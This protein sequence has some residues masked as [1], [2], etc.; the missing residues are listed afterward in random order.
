MPAESCFDCV[1]DQPGMPLYEQNV[2]S[3]DQNLTQSR[4]L[5]QTLDLPWRV[6]VKTQLK[7]LFNLRARRFR[8][9]FPVLSHSTEDHDTETDC[10]FRGVRR[11]P[12]FEPQRHRSPTETR[13]EVHKTNYLCVGLGLF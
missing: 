4:P 9:A 7:P 10:V 3:L 5:H 13:F 2:L 1:E 12:A 6:L 8:L 11:I